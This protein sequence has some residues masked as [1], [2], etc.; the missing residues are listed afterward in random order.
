[1]DP[2]GYWNNVKGHKEE[3]FIVDNFT[4]NSVDTIY[5]DNLYPDESDWSM[6][7]WLEMQYEKLV[8]ARSNN[9]RLP[10]VP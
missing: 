1:M 5:M 2:D 4:G 10:D 9:K 7:K 6:E 3:Q 8:V